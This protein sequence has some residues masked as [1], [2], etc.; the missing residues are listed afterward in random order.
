MSGKKIFKIA[1]E[2][3]V[4]LFL[5]V[6][7]D[8]AVQLYVV[9][10]LAASKFFNQLDAVKNLKRDIVYNPVEKIIVDNSQVLTK[11]IDKV[12][13][14]VLYLSNSQTGPKLKNGNQVNN[15]ETFCGFALTND[16]ILVTHLGD[17]KG[18]NGSILVNGVKTNYIV[19]A[20]DKENGLV[21]L[22][23]DLRNLKTVNFIEPQK[24][25]PGRNIFL[26]KEQIINNQPRIFVNQGIIEGFSGSLVETNILE[27]SLF[28]LCPA[29][30][31]EGN[32]VGLA[33][34]IPINADNSRGLSRAYLIPAAK[35][36]SFAGM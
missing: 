31:L 22:K 15:E 4:I 20:E 1:F 14:S 23:T 34:L 36:R 16:G 17:I 18:K 11:S 9:P 21:E 7:A 26:L 28:N 5:F 10:F 3:I 30:D 24:L 6:V 27:N 13:S 2:V 32:F 29:F 12:S 8:V 33:K 19:L 35:I 25:I